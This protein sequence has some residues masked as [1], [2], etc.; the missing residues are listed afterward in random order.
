MRVAAR[1][2]GVARWPVTARLGSSIVTTV[3]PSD[4]TESAAEAATD[5]GAATDEATSA[6]GA[7]I[8]TQRSGKPLRLLVLGTGDDA[9]AFR[10]R[11]TEAGAELAQRFSVRVTHV[12]VED[13][14][15]DEDARLVRARGAGLPI[16]RLADGARLLAGELVEEATRP[17]E[18]AN[19][20]SAATATPD[21]ASGEKED[22]AVAV[23]VVEIVDATGGPEAELAR[24]SAS[25]PKS[26]PKSEPDAAVAR[27]T[28]PYGGSPADRVLGDDADGLPVG[29]K[30][31]PGASL[32]RPR[33][34]FDQTAA[35]GPSDVFA[36]SA[37]EAALLFPRLA[38]DETSDET[39][40]DAAA[41]GSHVGALDVVEATCG[42]G[43]VETDD[44]IGA[45]RG[46]G[47]SAGDLMAAVDERGVAE[48]VTGNADVAV[49]NRDGVTSDAASFAD[50][51]LIDNALIAGAPAR[52]G[53][54]TAVSIA[55]ALVPLVSIG[56][57]TPVSIGYAAYRLR[58]RALAVATACYVVAV[59]ALFV[60]SA[61]SPLR[62]GS[63]APVGEL[64]TACLVASCFGGTVHS[65]LIRR[66]V[67]RRLAQQQD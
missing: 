4:Q 55:W 30:D 51:S 37:L 15:R 1:W 65:L 34:Q 33:E 25:E 52:V 46:D 62:T 67:F 43:D 8:P 19:V 44:S 57:L 64:L 54:T 32:I 31:A 23:D 2:G 17:D 66:R 6:A 18:A 61:A 29:S 48:S 60:L 12:V 63:H 3:T 35:S 50:E 56:L 11:A 20:A 21:G 14:V 53:G 45:D 49:D 41:T 28:E 7:S 39:S 58:S 42:C 40:D 59:A 26:E 10:E 16:L 13:G 22:D 38:S 5:A 36:G 24:E 47:A 27:D 9:A